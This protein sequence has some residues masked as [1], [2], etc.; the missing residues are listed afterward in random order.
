MRTEFRWGAR[1]GLAVF[2][3]L[4][5]TGLAAPLLAP[6][7]PLAQ[8]LGLR[9]MGPSAGHPLGTDLL[10]RDVLTRILYGAGSSFQGVAIAMLTTVVVGVP[11][12]LAAGFGGRVAD[13]L[14]MRIGDGL[15]SFPPIVL[16]IGII[17]MLGP[18]LTNSMTATGVIFAPSVARLLRSAVLPLRDA[19][20]VLVAGSLGASRM[21]V[22]LRHVL[23]NAMAPV[24]VQIFALASLAMII[25]AALG[26]LNL[27]VPPP[28]PS[29][30]QDLASAY[31]YFT[32]NPMATV[33]PGLAISVGA[34]SLSAL[35][36]GL[37]EVMVLR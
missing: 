27:G 20:F 37:R 35:G 13:E 18:S 32:G 21:R 25:Q 3:L 16:A 17:A 23:P 26:F 5:V 10:G 4:L 24:L 29:W 28:T 19:E 34:W 1:L 15:L 2:A 31:L 33:V 11:W 30:G 22:A 8:N 6:Y 9:L 7:D 14:L 12:G 36:D